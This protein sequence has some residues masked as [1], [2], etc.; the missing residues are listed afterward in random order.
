MASKLTKEKV[1]IIGS[2]L[3]GRSFAM[4]F[5][6][7]EYEVWLYDIEKTQLSG[8]LE[9]IKAQLKELDSLQLLRGSLT[10]D[11]QFNNIKTTDNIEQ[12]VKDAVFVHECVPERIELK[13]SIYAKI[14]KMLSDTCILATSTS[15]L[16]PSK[17]A[18]NIERKNR[19]IV[20]HPTNPPFYAPLVE[21]VPSPWV[22]SDV[23]PKAKAIM[24]KLGQVPVIL[25]K[26]IEGFVFNRIQSAVIKESWR[27]INDD[28]IDVEGL[29][30]VMTAGLGRR[31]AFIGPFETMYLNADGM[32]SY[33]DWYKTMLEGIMASFREP[34]NFLSGP[35][36]DQVQS[37][38]EQMVPMDT[39]P[40]RR[41]WRDKR[42]AA[43]AQLQKQM[44]D[45]EKNK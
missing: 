30:K 41:N 12:C 35:E 9:D 2:G 39:L 17:L 29:D 5:A 44:D 21:L 31:Y 13:T 23:V 11:Q 38:M 22:D 24:E 4:L 42:L 7:A 16:Q 36:L 45:A 33:A 15:A 1:G 34:V 14:D 43:F 20:V 3:I 8:A 37:E 10:A 26:E 25:K 40:A 6:A 18:A 28:V 27:L 19:F 32:Y